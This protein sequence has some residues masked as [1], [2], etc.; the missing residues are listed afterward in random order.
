MAEAFGT[1][2]GYSD[3]M[4]SHTACLVA[5]G[6]GARVIEKHLTLDRN[7]PG[8]DHKASATP[9]DFKQLCV[10]IREAEKTLGSGRKDPCEAEVANARYM[11]RSLVAS[12]KISAGEIIRE[13]MVV[14]KRPGTGLQPGM[15]P[16]L[17][18]R[19]ALH[20]I[21]KDELFSLSMCGDHE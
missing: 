10:A 17:L 11:R 5:I 18:G 16:T 19:V 6:L 20:D 8:P 9:E 14:F 15:L 1:I 12:R 4:Q 2:M 3:H 21:D 7:L 13:D